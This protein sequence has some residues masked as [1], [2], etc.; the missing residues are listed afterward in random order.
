MQSINLP[1]NNFGAFNFG[2]NA[3]PDYIKKNT[4]TTTT[5]NSIFKS[6]EYAKDT[7]IG[8]YRIF[9]KITAIFFCSL[10]IT[11]ILI[12]LLAIPAIMIL[13]GSLYLKACSFQIMIPIWLIVFGALSIIKN[14]STLI[15]RI[16]ALNSPD[17]NYSS[18]V[19]NIF[20]SFMALF[21]IVWFLCGNYWIY[22]DSSLV[23]YTE[24][25]IEATYCHKT[26]YLFAFWVITSIYILIGAGILLFCFSVCCTIFIPTKKQEKYL[27]K[28][29]KR[30]CLYIFFK[31]SKFKI[32]F[33]DKIRF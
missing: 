4:K 19:L 14:L 31:P 30:A 24:P 25:L 8:T 33:I 1:S 28:K 22:H 7:S 29:K 27:N 13:I 16:K 17:S 32:I 23:Q 11:T 15:Q 6:I 18:T 12:V 10:T 3:P 2:K 5:S 20:D 21:L 9:K 26:T